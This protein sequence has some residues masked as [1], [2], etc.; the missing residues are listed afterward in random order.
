[1]FKIRSPQINDLQ[2]LEEFFRS[3]PSLNIVNSTTLNKFSCLAQWIIPHNL[4]FLPS[5]HIAVEE[6]NI[7]GFIALRCASRPNNC[8]QIEEI[9]VL[10]EVRN[11]GIGEELLRYVLSIYGGYG[12]EH[13]LAEV[14]SENYPALSLFHQCAFRRYAK[15]CFYEKEFETL[16]ETPLLDKDFTIRIQTNNDLND[17]EKLDL[18]SIPPDL[19]PALGRSKEY[20][21]QK[22][23]TFV[24]VNKSRNLV[25]GWAQL[26]KLSDEHYFI[27]VLASPG[28]THLYELFLNTTIS[29]F[30]NE[31]K[32]FK[33]TIKVLDYLTELKDILTKSGFLPTNIKELL[34]RTILQKVK[35]RKEKTAKVTVPSAAPHRA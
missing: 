26:E 32:K 13:F 27:E 28:W 16:S 11:K 29:H 24:L 6:N 5:I 2:K 15:V 25:I 17:I 22:K 8:W 3:K 10:D 9:F 1:M 7:L 18:S 30:V 35:E 20:F 31:T 34:V 23:N 19:R 21:K 33:L 12:V 14:D 4:R